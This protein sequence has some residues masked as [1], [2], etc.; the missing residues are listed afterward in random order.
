MKIQFKERFIS[1]V[2]NKE[3]MPEYKSEKIRITP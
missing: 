3:N 1:K 2:H